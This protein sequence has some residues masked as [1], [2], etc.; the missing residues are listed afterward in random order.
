M[1][2][3]IFKYPIGIDGQ[4]VTIKGCFSRVCKIMTQ[5]GYPYIWMEV[6]EENYDEVEVEIRCVGTG[7]K[8]LSET[9]GQYID[10]CIDGEGYV[11]HYYMDTPVFLSKKEK[12]Q[13][14]EY[15]K[16]VDIINSL[17]NSNSIFVDESKI[18]L[19]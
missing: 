10:S 8:F 4:I 12:R 18:D 11:W 6:D 17:G 9:S 19:F 3:K 16:Y 1:A 13:A 7:W 14:E 5:G 2:K 15:M